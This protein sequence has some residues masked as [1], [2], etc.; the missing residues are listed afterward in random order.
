MGVQEAAIYMKLLEIE[1]KL[2]TL[3]TKEQPHDRTE[4]EK[5][6]KDTLMKGD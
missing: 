6:I 1:R 4:K 3:L 5:R 2:D